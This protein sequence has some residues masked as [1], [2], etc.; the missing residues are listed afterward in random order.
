MS[1]LTDIYEGWKNLLT[2]EFKEKAEERAKIC[3]MCPKLKDNFCSKEL[4]GCGCYIPAKT[5]SPNS[6]CPD[7]NW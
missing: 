6:T 7:N 2:G 3:A 1:K 4:G 5:A